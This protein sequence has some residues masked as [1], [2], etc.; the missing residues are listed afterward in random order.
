LAS[1]G[2]ETRLHDLFAGVGCDAFLHVCGID[3]EGEVA[4]DADATV[5]SAS[6]FKVAVAL[7]LFRQAAAGELDPT[8]RVRLDPHGSLR[9]PAGLALFSDE[10]EVS[11]RDLAVSMLTVSDSLAT[12]VLLE[13]V[14]IERVNELTRA[15]GLARTEIV[16][17]IRGMFDSLAEDMGFSRWEEAAA[18]PWDEADEE[19][20]AQALS[21]IRAA[22][23]C[24]PEQTTRTTPREMTRLL[25]AIW[26]DEAAPPEACRQVRAL[27]AKQLQ[28]ERIARG[29]GSPSA[30]V[31]F[32]GKTGTFGGA[33]RNEVGVVELARGGGRYAVAV[34]T[35][36]HA[37]YE[38]QR[39]IDDAIGV[40]AGLAVE[41]L[42]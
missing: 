26:L 10:V 15:L 30:G 9:A 20:T 23:T 13:R 1:D 22:R 41:S 29:F 11:L 12:D 3:S 16:G 21:R 42:R 33:F 37:L 7:E 35:R 32:S 4:L 6:V 17:D 2:V 25:S 24:D 14:G 28:R 40:A 38:R 39:E 5:V 34:F 8:E 19:T 31:R 27:M 18:Y 36:A